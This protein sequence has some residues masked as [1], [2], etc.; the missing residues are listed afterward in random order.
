[1]VTRQDLHGIMTQRPTPS[2]PALLSVIEQRLSLRNLRL[3]DVICREGSLLRAAQ[4]MNMTQS[5]VTKALQDLEASVGVRLFDRTNRGAIATPFGEALATHARIVLS[6]LRHATQELAELRDGS[7]GSVVI[8]TLLS[9]SVRLLPRAIS[10]VLL[11]RPN[12]RVRIVEGTNETLMPLLRRGDLDL[13]VGRL[14]EFRARQGVRQ[15]VLLRDEA[16]IVAGPAHPLV[17]RVSLKLQ[18]GLGYPWILPSP[19]TTL[20]RQI[21]HAF[22]EAGCDP[23]AAAVETV[24]VLV[25]RS[26]LGDGRHLAV[27]PA[28]L[29]QAERALDT[30]RILPIDL[31]GTSRPV[32]LTLRAEGRMSPAAQV[33]ITALKAE[34]EREQGVATP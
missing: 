13:V 11:D 19:E 7:G 28:D 32:G 34:A 5:A 30:V 17:G 10:A 15:E 20:R 18:E 2:D 12:L 26:L 25:S 1:M 8:G 22:R 9:A 3:V 27:W 4:S 33:M 14:P 24:S 29:A 16:R 31:P 21:D 23:P 6:Q